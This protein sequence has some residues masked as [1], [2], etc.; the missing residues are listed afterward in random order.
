METRACERS[1]RAEAESIVG[2]LVPKL[3]LTL[4]L[5]EDN[6]TDA[7]LFS[8]MMDRSQAL[9]A[10]LKRFLTVDSFLDDPAEIVNVIILDRFISPDGLSEGRIR[11]LKARHP[12][13]GIIMYTGLTLPSLRSSAVQEGA[14]AVVE[15]GS[16]TISE[17]ELL[18][19]TAACV[20]PK[21][22]N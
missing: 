20:G 8:H 12:E 18:L 6:D 10:T 19:M 7:L 21:V 15:K 1:G 3:P 22:S 4:A 11:E 2:T 9:S 14:M 17:M 13:A 16:L 5:I